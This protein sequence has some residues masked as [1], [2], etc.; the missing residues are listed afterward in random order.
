M[1]HQANMR[2]SDTS[3]LTL[4]GKKRKWSLLMAWTEAVVGELIRLT[5]WPVITLKHDDIANAIINRKTRDECRPNM[6]YQLSDD[7]KSITGVIVNAGNAKCTT[8]LPVTFPGSV[9]SASSA[10]KE[11][12]G[13]DPPT[14][15]VTLGGSKKTYTLSSPI[16]LR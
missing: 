10:T 12:V 13:K 1:F 8:P 4:L 7:R 16:K 2:I 14:L 5:Q 9:A 3:S 11:Q 15:W 6:A